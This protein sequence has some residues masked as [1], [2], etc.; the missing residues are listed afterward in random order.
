[1]KQNQKSG[2][3]LWCFENLQLAPSFSEYFGIL[4]IAKIE[5]EAVGNKVLLMGTAKEKNSAHSSANGFVYF[6][7]LLFYNYKIVK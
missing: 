1:M 7:I 2:Y 4:A 5:K 3:E 6:I